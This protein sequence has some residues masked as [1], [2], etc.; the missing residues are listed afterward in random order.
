MWEM[1]RDNMLCLNVSHIFG[2]VVEVGYVWSPRGD[3]EMRKKILIF[4]PHL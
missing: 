4:F 1:M 3:I 2:E